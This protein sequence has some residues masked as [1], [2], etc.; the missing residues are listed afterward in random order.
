MSNLKNILKSST[1]KLI[2]SCCQLFFKIK[3]WIFTYFIWGRNGNAP[4][5]ILSVLNTIS[6]IPLL[7]RSGKRCLIHWSIHIEE[8]K[9]IFLG[10]NVRLRKGCDMTGMGQI[11]IQDNVLIGPRV[12]FYTNKHIYTDIS[13]SILAQESVQGY[14]KIEKNVWIGGD[15]ILLPNI[16]IGEHAVVGAGSVVTKDVEPYTVVAGNPAKVIKKIGDQIAISKS[17]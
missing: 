2:A 15:C 13:K 9:N 5:D 6:L 12:K 11:I 3:R 4:T 16:S 14:I 1:W 8:P 10:E 17:T 7:G